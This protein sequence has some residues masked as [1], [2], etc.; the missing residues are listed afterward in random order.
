[1]LLGRTPTG[2]L[3]CQRVMAMSQRLSLPA[4]AREEA[5]SAGRVLN[6]YLACARGGAG[7]LT[8]DHWPLAA[9]PIPGAGPSWNTAAGGL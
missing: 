4:G 9:V 7:L 1:M 6:G 5:R 8:V 2:S 3:S